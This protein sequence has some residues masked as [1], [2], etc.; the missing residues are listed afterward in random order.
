MRYS[1]L[2]VAFL[3]LPLVCASQ[4]IKFE[5]GSWSEVLALAKQTGKP[6]F[7]DV[8]ASW[9]GPCKTMSR[10]IFPLKSVGDVYNA[11]FVCYQIDAEKG[12]G[13]EVAKKYNVT[14]YPTYIFVKADGTLFSRALGSMD[15]ASFIEVSKKALLDVNDPKPLPV[16]DAEYPQ[17]KK[18]PVF[19][20]NYLTK[21]SSLGLPVNSLFDEYLQAIPAAE[22]MSN[23]VVNLYKRE[24][25]KL[26]VADYAFQHLLKNR[27][28]YLSSLYETVDGYLQEAVLNTVKEAARSKDQV[29]LNTAI[30]T[31]DQLPY[32]GTLQSK[33]VLY[34]EYYRRTKEN[35]SYLKYATLHC[36]N[37]L[38][39]VDPSPASMKS[40]SEQQVLDRIKEVGYDLAQVDKNQL[41]ALKRS[42]ESYER[43][44][45]SSGLNSAAWT[46][47]ETVSDATALQD[48]LRWSDRSLQFAPKN[49]SFMDTKANILYK[50]GRKEEAIAVEKLAISYLPSNEVSQAKEFEETVRKME[51]GEKT[52]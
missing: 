15:A 34:M 19:L 31:F 44:R 27:T 43:E 49:V 9:C 39:K 36:N 20:L 7:V 26:K 28:S 23:N 38:M 42:M 29:L 24:G 33:D 35:D 25:E 50:L 1:L 12:E 13:I 47:F 18:D 45:I 22:R 16:W 6:V 46:V 4:G 37:N 3:L 52:W 21:K 32:S 40:R 48:A 8:Y 10:D 41:E 2:F 51:A 17:K 30:A 11:Q 5:E 14:A